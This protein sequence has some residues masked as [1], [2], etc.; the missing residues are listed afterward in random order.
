MHKIVSSKFLESLQYY[1]T[2]TVLAYLIGQ[3][4]HQESDGHEDLKIKAETK[5]KHQYFVLCTAIPV[6]PIT[7]KTTKQ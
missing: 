4:E 3:I 6:L 2:S 7:S 5:C 1:Q